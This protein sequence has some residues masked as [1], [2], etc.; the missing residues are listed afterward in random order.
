MKCPACQTD[1]PADSKFCKECSIPL[2]SR[3]NI[4]VSR[5]ETLAQ[6]IRELTAG[7][8]FAGRYHVIEELGKG[9]MGNVYKVFDTKI[10]EKIALKLIKPELAL[11][12]DTLE[13]FSREMTLARKIGHRNVCRMFDLGEADGVHFLTMEYVHGEDLKS[14]IR[15]SGTMSIGAVLSIGKQVADGLAEAHGLGIV[16]RDLKPQNIMIDKG[17]NAKIMDFGIARSIST[18]GITGVGVMVGT[19]EYMSPEQAEAKDVDR[20]SDIYSLGIILYEMATGRVPFEGETALAI[21]MKQKGETPKNPKGLNPHI[22]DDL[23]G[24]ILKCLDKDRSRRYQTASDVRAELERIEKGLPTTERVAPARK[25]FTSKQITV[26]FRLKKVILP[27][28]AFV[29]VA[30]IGIALIKG[31]P[32]KAA[33]PAA[34]SN[35]SIAVLPFENLGD[36]GEDEAFS[37]GITEDITTQLSKISELDVRSQTSAMKYKKSDLGIKEI[38]REL[39]VVYI[40]DG[41]VRRADS[42]V[43][44]STWLIDTATDKNIWADTFDRDLKEI[45]AIQGD[46]AQK[47]AAALKA[48]LTPTEKEQIEKKPTQDIRAYEYYLKGREY[49]FR[50]RKEDNE[51]AIELFKKAIELDPDY[52]L[53]HAELAASYSQRVIRFGFPEAEWFDAAIEQAQKA[54]SLDPNLAEGYKALGGL[55]GFVKGWWRKA[56][57]AFQKAVEVNPNSAIACTSLGQCYIQIGEFD[58]AFPFLK[59]AIALSPADA[60]PCAELGRVY[61]GLDDP[62][63]AEEWLKKALELQPDLDVAHG[64]LTD[65]YLAL[66]E[67][68]KAIEQSQTY[69]SLPGNPSAWMIESAALAEF[70]SGHYEKAQEYYQKIGEQP[71]ELGYIYW[72]AGRKDEA[73]KLFQGNLDWLQKRLEQGDEGNYIGFSMAAI[74]AVQGNKEE[75]LRWL[76]KAVDAG[77]RYYRD[78]SRYP[79]LENIRDDARFKRIIDETKAKVA[80]MRQRVEQLEKDNSK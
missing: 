27:A 31:L 25:P 37:S 38:G 45:F 74:Y 24:V 48:K 26:S 59:K 70:F 47:I 55:Y 65:L 42:T 23:A 9:G 18:K 73:K 16:H 62:M 12:A 39:N 72:K 77:Y 71:I 11:D 63:R 80:E 49:Y 68:N 10:K 19:P 43:R 46:I 40:L 50:Y 8:S 58:K 79:L 76:Q 51:Q 6:P 67:Y 5:S 35:R 15:M 29:A 13:R 28:A 57:E 53:A 3:K 66:G 60:F 61:Y 20:L 52:A 36:P 34:P 7:T 56:L 54:I 64:R 69:L 2:P 22:P 1:N 4:P 33:S 44:I 30:V 41:S 78:I 17:G 21:A 75:A 32:K 14:M